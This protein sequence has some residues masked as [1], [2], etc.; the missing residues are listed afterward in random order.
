[1]K[2]TT[3][4][5]TRPEIIRLSA[6]IPALDPHCEQTV[7]HT[8]QNFEESLSGVFFRDLGLRSPD[9]HL[10]IVE[11]TF[12]NQAACI[13]QRVDA[14]LEEQR[15]DRLLLLGDTNSALSAIV[16]ARR[17]IP[18]YHLEAGN[19]C[20]DDRVPEEINRRI[21]D[22]CSTVLLP[23]TCRSQ[24]NLVLEGIERDRIVVVGNPIFEVLQRYKDQIG[25]SDALARAGVKPREYFLATMHRAENVGDP[26]RLA[27]IIQGLER[28]AVR[29]DLPV[30][31]SVHPRT[32][33]CLTRYRITAGERVRLC[34]PFGFFDF[35]ALETGAR[36]VLTDSGTVQEECCILRVPNVTLR[37]TT[38]RPETIEVGSNVLVGADAA[39][40]EQGITLVLD[41][42]AEWNPPREYLVPRVSDVV[43]GVL[44][45]MQPGMRRPGA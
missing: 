3:I 14:L 32:A 25:A 37:D 1:M 20:Y 35:V 30:V 36:A 41:R 22:H 34:P 17:G 10:N 8:G 31:A 18:V 42:P 29:F 5:G 2:V 40:I 23:Y 24:E 33:E 26:A 12:A 9:V 28:V 43:V 44:V 4:L 21:I 15:P 13:L 38:E 6:I 11:T 39:R 19:R 7:V 27:G 45:G 16:A